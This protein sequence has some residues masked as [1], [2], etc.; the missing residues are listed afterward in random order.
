MSDSVL[1]DV[2]VSLKQQSDEPLY[3][4]LIFLSTRYKQDKY[5]DTHPLAVKPETVLIGK[6]Y[7]T[8]NGVITAVY[9]SYQ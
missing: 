1:T 4:P 5:F 7:E 3:E 8:R 6:R 9:D 2:E